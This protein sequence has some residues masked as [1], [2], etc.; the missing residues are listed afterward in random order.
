MVLADSSVVASPLQFNADR[1]LPV[2]LMLLLSP[3]DA[4]DYI[5]T[6]K[7]LQNRSFLQGC[8]HGH[9]ISCRNGGQ[10][11]HQ[12]SLHSVAQVPEG[13]QYDITKRLIGSIEVVT[14]RMVVCPP[15]SG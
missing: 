7:W 8:R 5:K 15:L 13:V 6:L 3:H 11:L 9:S 2:P 10:H 4:L 14:E 12:L 1:L